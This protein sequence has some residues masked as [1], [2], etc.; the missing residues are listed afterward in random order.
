MSDIVREDNLEVLDAQIKSELSK[1]E[2]K[3]ESNESVETSDPY[4]EEALK[5]NYDPNYS[6]PDKKSPEEFVKN[7]SFFKKI[8]AQNRKIEELTNLV[9]T[10]MDHS[11]KLEK[12]SYEKALN[13]LRAA[14]ENAVSEGDFVRYKAVET[15]E[16]VVAEELQKVGHQR[17]SPV[18]ISQELLNFKERNS[19]WFNDKP[20]NQLMV[21]DA[22]YI[23][24]RIAKEAAL[25]GKNISQEEH[26]RL[27]EEQIKK[28]HPD[29]FQQKDKEPVMSIKSTTSNSSSSEDDLGSRLSED[30]KRFI[31][32]AR[33]YG[34]KLTDKEY[35]KQL[36]TLGELR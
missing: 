28:L 22:D 11:T 17:S 21:E 29:R 2:P 27:V 8:K 7:A 23:D 9:K 30:Q 35:A 10:T 13:E 32:T 16:Q 33:Q 34:S 5:W 15:Q 24:K 18:E 14:K 25:V 6:G 31:R 36:Q 12:A 26:L 1:I 4:L 19:S 20:E 3:E